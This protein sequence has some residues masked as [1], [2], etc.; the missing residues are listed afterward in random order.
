VRC[1][2]GF[3]PYRGLI[4]LEEE[5]PASHRAGASMHTRSAEAMFSG[6]VAAQ[7]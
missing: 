3:A 2:A 5:A 6:F 7:K 1:A 4:R